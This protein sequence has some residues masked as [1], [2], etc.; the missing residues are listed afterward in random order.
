MSALRQDVNDK[1]GRMNIIG[2]TTNI[3]LVI[4][5]LYLLY[6]IFIVTVY[7]CNVIV[8]LNLLERRIYYGIITT[9]PNQYLQRLHFHLH[10]TPT[11]T[12]AEPAA[13]ACSISINT[14]S[15]T[16]DM[17]SL[18]ISNFVSSSFDFLILFVC[19]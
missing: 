7:V 14:T 12:D 18:L 19:N 4:M 2:V 1:N 13:I 5:V 15:N 8:I 16:G 17:Y 6:N 10:P 11:F 3:R 9:S